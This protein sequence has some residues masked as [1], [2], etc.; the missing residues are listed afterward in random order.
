M[1]SEATRTSENVLP[2]YLRPRGQVTDATFV[3]RD[4][5]S[6]IRKFAFG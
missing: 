6:S 3:V 1:R 4:S 2:M 5:S